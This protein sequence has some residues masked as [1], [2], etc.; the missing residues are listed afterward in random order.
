MPGLHS[1]SR[2][3]DRRAPAAS[4]GR[5]GG[6]VLSLDFELMW[7]VHSNRAS[8]RYAP[9]VL[10]ARKAIP[11]LLAL[12]E[13]HGVAC[14]WATVGLLFFRTRAGMERALPAARPRY[15][16]DALSSYGYLDEVGA[17]EES[18]P[19]HFGR[20]LLDIVRATPRQEIGTHTF[21]HYYWLDAE[22]DPAAFGADLAA[23][24][25][26]AE[27]LGLRLESLV[28]PRNQV[29]EGALDV[30][31][32]HGVATFRGAAPGWFNAPCASRHD[33]R[34][35]RALRA[36]DT[37]LPLAG[38]GAVEA[39]LAG[40]LVDVPA[41]RF[42]R[43]VSRAL[44]PLEPLRATRVLAGMRDA[45]RTDRLYHLWFHPHNFGENL[46]RNLHF[47]ERILVEARQLDHVHGWPSLTMGEVGRRLR[48][49]RAA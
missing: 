23:A 43:P 17:D 16:D 9:N 41:S 34:L 42:L 32:L 49:E 38:T 47:L 15:R 45:A 21:S 28:L 29:G 39:R 3:K 20:S 1:T 22:P 2:P 30:A 18:D 27:R 26:A 11:S 6:F 10:G 36:I 46:E 24:R 44:A 31:A 8:Q 25:G 14:T 5:R 12:F 7:G 19:L 35:R 13:R 40:G 33:G 37:Y 48:A 4:E